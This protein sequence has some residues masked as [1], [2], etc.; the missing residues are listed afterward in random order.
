[1]SG[2]VSESEECRRAAAQLGREYGGRYNIS[3]RPAGCY[4]S[5]TDKK[6]VNLNSAGPSDTQ[7]IKSTV[8]GVCKGGISD[9]LYTYCKYTK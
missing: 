3:E 8:G 1:M 5:S 9:L 7:N 6:G 2:I 4:Y